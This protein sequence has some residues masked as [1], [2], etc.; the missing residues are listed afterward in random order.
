MGDNKEVGGAVDFSECPS[1][2]RCPCGHCDLCGYPKHSGIHGP[3][4]GEPP[5]S[6]PWGHAFVPKEQP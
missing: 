5:G 4:Y 2:R 1:P 3:V 6:K